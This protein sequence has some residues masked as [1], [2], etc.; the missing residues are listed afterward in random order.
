MRL[1]KTVLVPTLSKS[2]A[3]ESISGMRVWRG[4]GGRAG[5]ASRR[6]LELLGQSAALGV[7]NSWKIWFNWSA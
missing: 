7:P 1:Q 4:R 2:T 3:W 5:N 6:M